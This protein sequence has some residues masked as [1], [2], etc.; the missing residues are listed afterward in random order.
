MALF[1]DIG[2]FEQFIRYGTFADGK[3][4]NHAE[5]GVKILRKEKTLAALDDEA[6]ELIL[7]VISYH[8][9]M[10]IPENESRVCIFFARL[11]RDAD[12]LDIFNLFADYYAAPE[13]ERSA[14]VELDLPDIPAITDEIMAG[15]ME[16][17]MV[18]M[19]QLKSLNDFKLL[20]MAWIYDINF[21]PTFRIIAKR[22][23]LDIIR[24]TLPDSES[25]DQIYHRL[26]RYLK[27]RSECG[28]ARHP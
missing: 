15:L 6:Q 1:H 26:L 7:K 2:R 22:G 11:L 10:N 12:K 3:S 25:I 24:R 14:A 20:Q 21:Q 13:A 28:D 27:E 4:E 8:N 5:L 18:G 23:Y 17:K 19:R 16:G 9:R